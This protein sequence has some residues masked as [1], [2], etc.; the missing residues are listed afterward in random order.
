VKVDALYWDS[1]T[2]T[3]PTD[4]SE[5]PKLGRCYVEVRPDG[6]LWITEKDTGYGYVFGSTVLT[7]L[8][9]RRAV[10][11]G[12]VASDVRVDGALPTVEVTCLF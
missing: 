5:S 1:V 7:S 3:C 4:P 8:D 12:D 10:F 9:S 2:V 6:M 11:S